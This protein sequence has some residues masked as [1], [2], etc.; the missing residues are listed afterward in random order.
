MT[1]NGLIDASLRLLGLEGKIA[2][3]YP[4]HRLPEVRQLLATKGLNPFRIRHV[5]GQPRTEARFFLITAGKD[6]STGVP[7]ED[8]FNM[9]HPDGSH[10]I[11]MQ[12]IYASYNYSGRSHSF[13]EK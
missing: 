4:W 11:R 13:R 6:T 10:T 12:E 5:F 9:V 7:T 1:L 8:S 2:L 3:V